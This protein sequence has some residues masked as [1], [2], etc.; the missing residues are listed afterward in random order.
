MDRGGPAFALLINHDD[1][2][3]EAAYSDKGGDS[4]AAASRYH[5]RVVSMRDDW[6]NVFDPTVTA[7]PPSP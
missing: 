3:R 2:A 7:R 6:K 5:F 1:A 4:L